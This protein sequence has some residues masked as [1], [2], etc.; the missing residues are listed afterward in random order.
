MCQVLRN[1]NIAF[2]KA[3]PNASHQYFLT[4]LLNHYFYV[5]IDCALSLYELI[6]TV[7]TL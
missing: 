5:K 2:S 6:E 7:V 1:T 4:F 3:S